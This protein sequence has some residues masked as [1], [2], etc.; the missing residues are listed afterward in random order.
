MQISDG[1][2]RHPPTTV[3]VRKLEWLPFCVVSKCLQCI[4][5][6]CHKARYHRWSRGKNW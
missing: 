4:V 2:G 6:F 3:G 5:W 1:S